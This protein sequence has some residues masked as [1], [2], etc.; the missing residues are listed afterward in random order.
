[1]KWTG[2][3]LKDQSWRSRRNQSRPSKNQVYKAAPFS[4]S[5]PGAKQIRPVISEEERENVKNGILTE[6]ENSR[7]PG[8]KEAQVNT[9]PK[10]VRRSALSKLERMQ[11]L[12][13]NVV[14]GNPNHHP[15]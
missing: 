11:H 4:K 7:S 5:A 15:K 2:I 10:L 12:P 6:V 3:R 13:P 14:R 8:P 1:M 9:A